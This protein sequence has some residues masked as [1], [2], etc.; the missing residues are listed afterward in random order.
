MT[1]VLPSHSAPAS[2]KQ[3][4][5]LQKLMA[6]RV[7]PH[8][9]RRELIVEQ[10]ESPLFTKQAASIYIEILLGCERKP[11]VH[12]DG[13]ALGEGFYLLGDD[14]FKVQ[15]SKA[16]NLYAKQFAYQGGRASYEY[17]PGALKKLTGAVRLTVEVAAEMGVKF[18][19][20]VVCARL[21]TDPE[22]VAAG[23]GP[24]CKGKL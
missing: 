6:E 13:A 4:A 7:L 10:I 3:Y 8:E 16:G 11:A 5:F 18:G 21:L 23:I 12:D 20:C 15:A 9:E 1:K 19:S 17:A 24:I 14:V 22:S 2:E